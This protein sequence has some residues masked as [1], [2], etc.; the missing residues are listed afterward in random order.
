VGQNKFHSIIFRGSWIV[1]QPVAEPI[2]EPLDTIGLSLYFAAVQNFASAF[3]Y[4]SLNELESAKNELAVLQERIDDTTVLT[5]AEGLHETDGASSA[6]DYQVANI[7]AGQ[8]QALLLFREG[9]TD[10]AL[11]LL[12]TVEADENSRPMQYGPPDIPK[13]SAELMGEMLLTL[14]RGQDAI[15]HFQQALDRNTGR[16]L[17]LLGLARAQDAAGD[18]RAAASW[19][20]ANTNWRS[21]PA[22][23]RNTRYLWLQP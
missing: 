13:P 21:D 10:Q 18:P 19:Q 11:A 14:G 22:A 17:S 3:H 2:L 16:T 23:L 7:V 5:V 20:Q 8:L 4:I 9:K 6:E 15:G 12:A 1:E